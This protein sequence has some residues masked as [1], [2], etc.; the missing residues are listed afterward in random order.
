[1]SRSQIVL[2]AAISLLIYLAGAVYFLLGAPHLVHWQ[3][4]VTEKMLGGNANVFAKT[5]GETRNDA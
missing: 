4:K 3:M 5:N 1:M 2:K